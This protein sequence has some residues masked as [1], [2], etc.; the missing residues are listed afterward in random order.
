MTIKF[1]DHFG[2]FWV[3]RARGLGHISAIFSISM[4]PNP[5]TQELK[6]Y[7]ACLGNSI[8]S[9]KQKMVADI[10]STFSSTCLID[11]KVEIESHNST[12]SNQYIFRN[13]L[14]F[15]SV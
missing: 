6:S 4:I 13:C 1:C 7:Q 10:Q 8:L 15:Q 3:S 14:P 2:S 9:L 5:F 11:Q 12:H